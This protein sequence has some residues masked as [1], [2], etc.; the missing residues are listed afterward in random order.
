[1]C[2]GALKYDLIFSY[3]VNQE[4]VRFDVTFTS[5][6]PIPNKFVVPV[7]R[8]QTFL[9]NECLHDDLHF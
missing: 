4:P 9:Y 1:M 6:L 5:A 3:H 2:S 8:I 7:N